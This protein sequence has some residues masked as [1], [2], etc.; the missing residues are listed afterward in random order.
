MTS[1]NA[2]SIRFKVWN[3]TDGRTQGQKTLRDNNERKKEKRKITG[4]YILRKKKPKKGGRRG[5][6][7]SGGGN[8]CGGGFHLVAI[9]CVRMASPRASIWLHCVYFFQAR[10]WNMKKKTKKR[11]TSSWWIRIKII[12]V[13]N[14]WL[15]QFT[16][17]NTTKKNYHDGRSFNHISFLSFFQS[18]LSGKRKW[19]FY[20]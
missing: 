12:M 4:K 16:L 5:M 20:N 19:L 9:V 8:R 10:E 7:I 1:L 3:E 18:I 14:Q 13:T 15:L 2:A 17:N 11:N 6:P